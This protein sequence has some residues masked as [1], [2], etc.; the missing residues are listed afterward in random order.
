MTDTCKR[1]HPLRFL[2]QN[3]QI[4]PIKWH[5]E[6]TKFLGIILT[7]FGFDWLIVSRELHFIWIKSLPLFF[8]CL[9]LWLFQLIQVRRVYYANI[10][11]NWH[12]FLHFFELKVCISILV[13][14][15]ESHDLIQKCNVVVA[16]FANNWIRI[17]SLRCILGI[18]QLINISKASRSNIIT[19]SI[20][21]NHQT[22]FMSLNAFLR[23]AYS[24]HDSKF[25]DFNLYKCS[26]QKKYS[27]LK[28]HEIN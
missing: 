19:D 6:I 4:F 14:S 11:D 13:N 12:L 10:L 26:I 16:K 5:D 7:M 3:I 17:G 8:V 9:I 23:W 2:K 1:K 15:F 21:I 28:I 18:G 22:I 27:I 20:P 25:Y 24:I